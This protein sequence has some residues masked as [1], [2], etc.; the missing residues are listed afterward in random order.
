MKKAFYVLIILAIMGSALTTTAS[1]ASTVSATPPPELGQLK[2]CKVAGTGVTQGKLFTFKAGGSTFSVPAGPADNGYCVLA[3]QYPLNTQLTIEE[4]TPA[5]YYVSRIEVKPDRVVN[6][7][8]ANGKVVVRIGSGVTEAIFT[9]KVAGSPTP[10][11]T[12]TSVNTATPK[13]TNTPTQTP[14]CAPNCTP[15]PTPIPTGRLQICK[16]ADG[17]GVT[18]Y[19]T[20][21]FETRSRS[22]PVGACAGL[23]SVNAG[24]LTISE[25][26]QAGYELTDVYTIPSN[27]LISKNLNGGSATVTIVEGTASSQTIVVF[28]NRAITSNATITPSQT[29]TPT[30]SLTATPTSTG[31]VTPTFTPTSTGIVTPSFT[32]TPTGS[33]TATPTSTGS[34]TPT[35][36]PTGTPTVCLPSVITVDFSQV[37]LG[38]LVEGPGSVTPNLNID[39]KGEAR[40]IGEGIDPFLY[41]A[42]GSGTS[43]QNGGI[44]SSGGFSDVTTQQAG[45]AHLYTFTFAPFVSVSDFSLHMLDFGDLNP[46]LN[47]NHYASM[48][49]Y[50]ANGA[51]VSKH[52]LSYTTLAESLPSSSNIYGNLSM[53]GDALGATPGQPGNWT[54]HVSGNGIVKVVLEFGAGYDPNIGFD[55]L[56]FAAVCP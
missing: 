26:K 22:V 24:R 19:F 21:K 44:A 52:E 11:R 38:S 40:R 43:I 13:S 46:T 45:Q 9:N 28:R 34:V 37:P 48:T 15:T 47:T 8:T 53:S 5:G 49:A 55:I 17:D 30:G 10:T 2:I 20:F 56:S 50:A 4:V 29:P 1:A 33:L 3:G 18:G 6:R 39:A 16:E 54:W 35:F 7:D 41:F 23:I 25:T 42:T 51:V 12:P 32:P 31:S 36:T 27:R 14:S